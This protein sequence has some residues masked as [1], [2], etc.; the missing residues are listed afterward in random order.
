MTEHHVYKE[1]IVTYSAEKMYLLVNDLSAYPD[2]VV[3][4]VAGE[5]LTESQ[6]EMVGRLTFSQY[7]FH[8]SFTTKNKLECPTAISLELVDGP[9]TTLS[10]QWRFIACGQSGCKVSLKLDFTFSNSALDML[11]RP[12]FQR[13]SRELVNTFVRRADAVYGGDSSSLL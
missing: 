10:G 3:G 11:F 13:V 1:A 12:I 2:F 5:V 4:C 7:G 9:F 8:Y 6:A